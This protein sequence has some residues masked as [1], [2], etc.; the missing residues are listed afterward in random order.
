MFGRDNE[1]ANLMQELLK[2]IVN[3]TLQM[4]SQLTS[5]TQLSE[6]SDV[7]EAFFL[8]LTQL[9]KKVPHLIQNSGVDLGALFQCGKYLQVRLD[10]CDFK[11]FSHSSN[12]SHHNNLLIYARK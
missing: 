2:E 6:K 5:N 4:C 10:V 11:D 9:Y 7:L 12:S 1:Y 8:M 3:T